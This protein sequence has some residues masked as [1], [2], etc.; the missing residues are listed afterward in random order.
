MEAY[1]QTGLG[2]FVS[3][4]LFI[5]GYRQTIGAKRE[6]IKVANN[7]LIE[8]ILRRLIL[9]SYSP[10]KDDVK[11]LIEG[12][13][14]DY[15]VKKNELLNVEQILN[16]IYTRIFENDLISQEQREE[17]LERLSPLFAIEKEPKQIIEQSL[18]K[19][20]R[21]K[22]VFNYVTILLGI[23]SSLIGVSIVSF[24]KLV[25]F[26]MELN[27]SLILSLI[28]SLVTITI[29]YTFL[30]F[31]DSQ[32]S[33]EDE[34]PTTNR[35]KEHI[36]F[37]KDVIK[38]LDKHN[39][40]TIIPAEKDLGFDLIA[41]INDKKIAVEIKKWRQRPPIGFVR[42]VIQKLS[43]SMTKMS[44]ND[45]VVIVKDTYGLNDK[46]NIDNNIRLLSIN[47]IEKMKQ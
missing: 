47:E 32:E 39:I 12:K 14:R 22:K 23:L 31:K 44:I 34:T 19:N 38:K 2:I 41:I 5:L 20:V 36:E 24:D 1:F 42:Q 8:T 13:A 33:S 10:D 9:E 27:S 45:G 15:K 17:N 21:N 29:A 4:F 46:L 6:R 37:E 25:D 43:D 18:E 11:R 35:F 3:V 28:G 16:T 40:K 30:R 26:N 7:N